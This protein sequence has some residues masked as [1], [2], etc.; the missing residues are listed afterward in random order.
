MIAVT[1]FEAY[2][3]AA[4]E[5]NEKPNVEHVKELVCTTIKKATSRDFPLESVVPVC[6][7]WAFVAKKLLSQP[8][9]KDLLQKALRWLEVCPDE[10]AESLSKDDVHPHV[11]ARKLEAASGIKQ[12]EV[13]YSS[14]ILN[15]FAI[16]SE[17]IRL[18]T[19]D[20]MV[21]TGRERERELCC[22]AYL[23]S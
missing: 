19:N 5:A 14:C 1:H 23:Q 10:Y 6:S 16:P 15:H 21:S 4:F 18:F 7:Q 11:V 17:M 3:T 9:N 2:Y 12:L 20:F 22:N 8:Q 13:R